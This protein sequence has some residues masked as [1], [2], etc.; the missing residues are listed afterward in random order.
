M[1]VKISLCTVI[2]KIVINGINF[3]SCVCKWIILEMFKLLVC[4]DKIWIKRVHLIIRVV[5][6]RECCISL[7]VY[8]RVDIY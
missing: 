3:F 5:H 4:I 7:L 2:K 8:D 1:G 6:I